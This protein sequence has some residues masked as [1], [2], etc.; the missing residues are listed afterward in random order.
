MLTGKDKKLFEK[1]KEDLKQRDTEILTLKHS[2]KRITDVR[3]EAIK[4]CGF[5]I[6]FENLNAFSI[7]RMV[8]DEKEKTSI[9]YFVNGKVCEWCFFCSRETHERLVREFNEYVA[10]KHQ[11]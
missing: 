11:S 9:G 7:E 6:D 10:K 1:M 4:N 5:S 8:Q 2:L 3:D